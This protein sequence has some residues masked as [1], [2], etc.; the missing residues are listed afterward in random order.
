M[1]Q[2]SV[3]IDSPELRRLKA[4]LGELSRVASL[5][6]QN[7]DR[8]LS[9]ESSLSVE[10]CRQQCQVLNAQRWQELQDIMDKIA[11]VTRT[12]NA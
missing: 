4:M 1:G 12:S 11:K 10:F 9:L 6:A 2:C 8:I 3:P 5:L 7:Y